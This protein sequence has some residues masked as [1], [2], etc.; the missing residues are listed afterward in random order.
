MGLERFRTLLAL[1]LASLFL[2]LLA[3]VF[4]LQRP[5]SIGVRMPLLRLRPHSPDISCDGRWVFVELLDDGTTEVNSEPVPPQGLSAMVGKL[6]ESHAERVVYL[7]PSPG[8]SYARFVETLA[9]LQVS[10]PDTHVGVL[11]GAV[12]DAY[13]GQSKASILK[14]TYLPCDIVWPSDEFR[15]ATTL[16]AN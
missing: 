16:P 5:V 1:P 9:A 8:I 13:K 6:M 14:R 10:A 4:A 7:V 3:C 11:S 12:R 15:T 2:I